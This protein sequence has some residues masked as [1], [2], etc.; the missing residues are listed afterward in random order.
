VPKVPVH[1]RRS[2]WC[3]EWK[4]QASHVAL[5]VTQGAMLFDITTSRVLAPLSQLQRGV[6]RPNVNPLFRIAP[7]GDHNVDEKERRIR[8]R[9]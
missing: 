3:A 7:V 8:T 2:L 9:L 5:G 6:T 1:D 4:P